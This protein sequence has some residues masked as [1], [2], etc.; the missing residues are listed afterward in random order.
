MP[1]SKLKPKSKTT[2]KSGPKSLT[3]Q[4]LLALGI[5]TVFI[6]GLVLA[7]VLGWDWQSDLGRLKDRGGYN[8]S[9]VI[10]PKKA[11]V[12][13]VV[14]GDTLELESGQTVRLLGINAPDRGEPGFLE[15]RQYL[16]NL[17][18]GE[19]VSLEYDSYQDDKY[20][21]LLAY[22]FEPCSNSLLCRDGQRLVNAVL[23]K[24]GY[25]KAVFYQDRAKLKYQEEIAQ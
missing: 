3:R 23:V 18:D 15:S 4:I 7:S 16:K 8:Q 17:I 25:A 14:D 13:T 11:T 12:A 19:V 1:K 6:P 22:V 5:P 10:F 24:Q 21:R 9:T 2:P 20:G